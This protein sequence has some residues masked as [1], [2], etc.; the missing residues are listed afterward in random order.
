MGTVVAGPLGFPVVDSIDELLAPGAHN[1]FER[2]AGLTDGGYAVLDAPPR[3]LVRVFFV[4]VVLGF[5]LFER[6]RLGRQMKL[7]RIHARHFLA[8]R[9]ATSGVAAMLESIAACDRSDAPPAETFRPVLCGWTL[10]ADL[11]VDP[12]IAAKQS[13]AAVVGGE[14]HLRATL[15]LGRPC[16]RCRAWH[17]QRIAAE[18]PS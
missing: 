7:L 8:S 14:H 16:L 17:L 12:R 5:V 10:P 13:A 1:H 4:L 6:H 3:T 9:G 15:K 18:V 11:A 2:A